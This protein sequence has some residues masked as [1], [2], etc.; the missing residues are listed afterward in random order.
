MKR[1]G[2]LFEKVCTFESLY[3][4]FKKAMRGSGKTEEA[5]AFEFE[6]EHLLF[7]LQRELL[8]GIYRPDKYR[9]FQVYE[10]KERTISVASFR[11]RV[12]HHSVVAAL[13]PIFERVFIYDSYATRKEKGTH[14]C[15]RRAQEF[16]RK[17][18]YYL[19][20]DINKYFES[21]DH[22]VLIGLIERK[23]K[24]KRLLDLIKIIV[25]NNDA[26]RGE[27]TGKGLPIG[28]LTSQFFANVY[29]DAF[30]HYIKDELGCK[31][32]LRYMDD[33]VIFSDDKERLKEL[34][35]LSENFLEQ[36]LCLKLKDSATMINSRLNG[37]PFLGFRVFPSLLRIKSE[38]IKRLKA[39]IR[40]RENEFRRGL[41]D[42][43]KYSMS[44]ASIIGFAGFA[45]SLNLRK[46]LFA[47][48]GSGRRAAP[49][50]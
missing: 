31:A 26:S 16:M 42:E 13:E 21:M 14:K 30:D 48:T 4:A 35:K 37:L 50:G 38:N 8:N 2:N 1:T 6:L 27:Q 32:Y 45:D 44:L 40:Q 11:D 3:R 23:I 15:V 20:F 12:V 24:D 25:A 39:K 17:N 29:L 22:S 7:E 34:L 43:D 9:Y 5:C 49:T 19:K 10:P 36:R 18:R 41:I 33:C 47:N 28:N 46:R